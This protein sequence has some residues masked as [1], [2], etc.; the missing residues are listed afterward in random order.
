MFLRRLRFGGPANGTTAIKAG[1]SQAKSITH[2]DIPN[3]PEHSI[4]TNI[5]TSS[6]IKNT[7]FSSRLTIY[8]EIPITTTSCTIPPKQQPLVDIPAVR[9]RGVFAGTP[10]DKPLDRAYPGWM[11]QAIEACQV[12][13]VSVVISPLSEGFWAIFL[14]DS[15]GRYDSIAKT[16]KAIRKLQATLRSPS[17]KWMT[18]K[19]YFLFKSD[20]E[21]LRTGSRVL[22]F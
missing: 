19:Q 1:G 22:S 21:L 4:S 3:K 2:Q 8:F 12:Y 5:D 11:N 15:T 14:K 18:K 13:G 16:I 20:L 7:V 6:Q 10:P 9:R 17:I